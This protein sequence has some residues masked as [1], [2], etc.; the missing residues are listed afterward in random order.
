M[1]DDHRF[2]R[3]VPGHSGRKH[4]M[5]IEVIMNRKHLPFKWMEYKKSE[6]HYE[7]HFDFTGNN[8]NWKDP[9]RKPT[10]GNIFGGRKEVCHCVFDVDDN[11]PLFDIDIIDLNNLRSKSHDGTVHLPGVGGG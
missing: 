2:F 5:T 8:T 10:G 4:I 9:V 1:K 7:V 11:V 3:L 6:N